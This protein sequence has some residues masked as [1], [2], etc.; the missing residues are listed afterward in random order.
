LKTH[1]RSSGENP[2]SLWISG[3]ATPMIDVSMMTMNCASAMTARADQR[4]G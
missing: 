3:R 1:E 2:R 4:R